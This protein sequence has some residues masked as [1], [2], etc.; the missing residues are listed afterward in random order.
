M[1]DFSLVFVG[2]VA[3]NSPI[4][5]F[6]SFIN[7][8]KSLEDVG[9]GGKWCIIR[10][11]RRIHGWRRDFFCVLIRCC[12]AH[13]LMV[14]RI[15]HEQANVIQWIVFWCWK[16]Y[17]FHDM[18]GGECYSIPCCTSQIVIESDLHWSAKLAGAASE[19]GFWVKHAGLMI[20]YSEATG[21]CLFG[22][23]MAPLDMPYMCMPCWQFH[24]MRGS[25]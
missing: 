8:P 16:H 9:L 7:S 13:F 15:L 2:R 19:N 4:A 12:S 18:G 14:R 22:I 21:K 24:C 6:C 5:L 25:Q 3:S 17:N 11:T 20:Y 23:L 10:G 1:R